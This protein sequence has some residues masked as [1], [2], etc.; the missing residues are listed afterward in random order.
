MSEA[1]PGLGPKAPDSHR[2]L[3]LSLPKP[4]CVQAAMSSHGD[5]LGSLLISSACYYRRAAAHPALSFKAPAPQIP[6]QE[7]PQ[8]LPSI[9]PLQQE[10]Q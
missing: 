2:T 1:E 5:F 8:P 10:T 6:T 7:S 3:E 9:C 4:L